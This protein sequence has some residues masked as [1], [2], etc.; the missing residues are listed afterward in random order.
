[1]QQ[2]V[3]KFLYALKQYTYP[4][5]RQMAT[6]MTNTYLPP[7]VPRRGQTENPG[8]PTPISLN[9]KTSKRFSWYQQI[10]RHGH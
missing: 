8:A 9:L 5:M 2:F 10:V 4:L 7:V 1:M 6:G 3:E